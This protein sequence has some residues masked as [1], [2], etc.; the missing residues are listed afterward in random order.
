MTIIEALKE[1]YKNSVEDINKLND[2]D[3]VLEV[4]RAKYGDYKG[5]NVAEFIQELIINGVSPESGGG[6]SGGDY[7]I[8]TFSGDSDN[9]TITCDW[10]RDEIQE[11]LTQYNSLAGIAVVNF[12]PSNSFSAGG[13]WFWLNEI[14]GVLFDLSSFGMGFVYNEDGTVTPFSDEDMPTEDAPTV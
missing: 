7:P 6:S 2:A 9:P 4:L 12:S 13:R 11:A 8:L 5:S 1:F 3:S 10:S 14:E